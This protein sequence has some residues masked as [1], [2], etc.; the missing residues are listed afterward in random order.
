MG[1]SYTKE[2]IDSYIKVMMEYEDYHERFTKDTYL[3]YLQK[4][5]NI[6]ITLPFIDYFFSE[7]QHMLPYKHIDTETKETL[8][9]LQSRYELVI[10]TNYFKE[11]QVSRL[12]KLKLL[13]YFI[14]IYGPE[15]YRKPYKEAFLMAS[16]P[17]NIDECLM[18]GDSLE[19]DYNGAKNAGMDAILI[20][21]SNRKESIKQ[22]QRIL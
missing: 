6:P 20:D 21:S 4:H 18:I 7:T 2:D 11:V 16:G 17:H 22:L 13:R 10:L 14:A 5:T 19:L 15:K 9:Y 8:D 3:R 12:D 1:I